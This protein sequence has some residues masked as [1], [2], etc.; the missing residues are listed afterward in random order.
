M[1]QEANRILK[2]TLLTA[3]ELFFHMYEGES[4]PWR[5]HSWI[6]LM[7]T[8]I[9]TAWPFEACADLL[10]LSEQRRKQ[11]HCKLLPSIQD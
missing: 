2:L 3:A 8:S 9:T 4:W 1:H 7:N 10:L 6:I 11:F 5:R